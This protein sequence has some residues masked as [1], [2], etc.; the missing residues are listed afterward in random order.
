MSAIKRGKK[1][2]TH[3]PQS[4]Y[5]YNE[6]KSGIF[7]RLTKEKKEALDKYKGTMSYGEAIGIL[8]D[9][10]NINKIIMKRNI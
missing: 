1:G 3:Y 2:R 8:V 4:Y 10:Y 6:R 7:I 5:Q 9:S